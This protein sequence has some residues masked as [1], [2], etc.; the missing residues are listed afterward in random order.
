MSYDKV[1]DLVEFKATVKRGTYFAVGFGTSMTDCDMVV[2]QGQGER[3]VVTDRWSEGYGVPTIDAV[4][5]VTVDTKA[6][7][8]K[9]D[10]Y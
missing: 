3:G 6:S 2:F 10:T 5:S 7:A 1:K 9:D 4:Q 8:L